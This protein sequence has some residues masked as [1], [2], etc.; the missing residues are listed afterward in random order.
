MTDGTL[1]ARRGIFNAAENAVRKEGG[2]VQVF[3][4]D[5]RT[6]R[7]NLTARLSRL[8]TV[9]RDS[10]PGVARNQIR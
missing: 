3:A 9:L 5:G 8:L 1:V 4:I 10:V 7:R 6:F 2:G